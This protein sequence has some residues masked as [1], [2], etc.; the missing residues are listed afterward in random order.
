[1]LPTVHA[2]AALALTAAGVAVLYA[3]W[4][5][6]LAARGGWR[7]LGWGALAAALVPWTSA[8]GLEFG[9]TAALLM[10][11]VAAW[12]FVFLSPGS[13]KRRRRTRAEEPGPASSPDGGP[14]RGRA[15]RWLRHGLL[16]VLAVPGAGAAATAASIA[17]VWLLPWTEPN[18]IALVI[19]LMP[20]LWGAAAA[21]LC[22][23][24][25]LARPLSVVAGGGL[26]SAWA[27]W[28]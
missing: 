4:R 18:R 5:G 2:V 8:L 7:L 11:P 10:P 23:D 16:F 6:R 14:A 22:A 20:V 3:V 15:L 13:T 21:W 26:L 19:F 25:R 9:V 17:L 12:A 24:D 27:V 28:V 1:M